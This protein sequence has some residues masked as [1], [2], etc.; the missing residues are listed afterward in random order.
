MK[1]TSNRFK[2]IRQYTKPAAY[3]IIAALI[4]FNLFHFIKDENRLNANSTWQTQHAKS[5]IND[6]TQDAVF[7]FKTTELNKILA[8]RNVQISPSR[9]FSA[10]DYNGQLNIYVTNIQIANDAPLEQV[11]HVAHQKKWFNPSFK[12][13]KMDGVSVSYNQDFDRLATSKITLFIDQKNAPIEPKNYNENTIGYRLPLN[14][15]SIWNDASSSTQLEFANQTPSKKQADQH[16]EL[17]LYRKAALVYV[18][19]IVPKNGATVD[20]SLVNEIF[21][22]S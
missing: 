1:Q 4:L 8:R 16:I 12:M 20:E 17:R 21:H 14:E 18:I 19:L 9:L 15:F 2:Q 22:F 11:V 7:L 13:V 10:Y 3:G 5:T 6:T